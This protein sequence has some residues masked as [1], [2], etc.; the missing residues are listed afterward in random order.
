MSLAWF[1]HLSFP[2]AD[3]GR[4][5]SVSHSDTGSVIRYRPSNYSSSSLIILSA[6]LKSAFSCHY[7]RFTWTPNRSAFSDPRPLSSPVITEES[8]D[9]TLAYCIIDTLWHCSGNLLKSENKSLTGYSLSISKGGSKL[10][11]NSSQRQ[12]TPK[13]E[14]EFMTGLPV[15]A[16][17]KRLQLRKSQPIWLAR[18]IKPTRISLSI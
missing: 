14:S 15:Y 18:K 17:Y 7:A 3:W 2:T 9:F 6:K 4:I 1:G 13:V 8:F 16:E 12:K 10:H 11:R 5:L